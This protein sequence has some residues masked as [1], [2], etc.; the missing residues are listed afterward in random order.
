MSSQAVKKP[1]GYNYSAIE[2]N[3]RHIKDLFKKFQ[4]RAIRVDR[5][6][7]HTRDIYYRNVQQLRNEHDLYSSDLQAE[8]QNIAKNGLP[9]S[10]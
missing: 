5:S 4:K 7:S 6:L 2:Q 10:A 1:E 3:A 9:L 8:L